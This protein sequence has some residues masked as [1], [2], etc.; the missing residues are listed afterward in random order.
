MLYPMQVIKAPIKTGEREI[1]AKPT[2]AISES[3]WLRW[4][5]IGFGWLMIGVGIVGIFVPVMPTTVFLIAALW[6]FSRSSARFQ[7]W[8]WT[9]SAFGPP[10]RNWHLHQVIPIRG[11]VL[12]VIVMTLSFVYV[13][14]WVAQDWKLPTAAGAVMLPAALYIVTRRSRPPETET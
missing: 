8:L 12:A 5:L 1:P 6:A 9:H 7:T 10:V 14:I 13:A 2:P 4:A 3:A 11:K